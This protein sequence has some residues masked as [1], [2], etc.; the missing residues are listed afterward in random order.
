VHNLDGQS[1]KGSFLAV[2]ELEI[3][4]ETIRF[5]ESKNFEYYHLVP[6]ITT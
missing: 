1:S 3:Q 6:F 4:K 5:L 2:L